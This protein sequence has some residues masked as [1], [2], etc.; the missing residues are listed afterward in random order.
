MQV[1]LHEFN[2]HLKN[3]GFY[4]LGIVILIGAGLVKGEGFIKDPSAIDK[5]F[6]QF[7]KSFLAV[8]GMNG[9]NISTLNGYYGLLFFYLVVIGFIYAGNLG[10]HIF[11]DEEVD[12]TSEFL[13]TKPISRTKLFINKY[14][15]GLIYLVLFNLAIIVLSEVII[16]KS[17]MLESI[18]P[19]IVIC[20]VSLF[21]TQWLFFSL[22]VMLVSSLRKLKKAYSVISTIV[23]VSYMLYIIKDFSVNLD[24]LK[25]ITPLSYLDLVNIAKLQEYSYATLGIAGIA[26][27]VFTAIGLFK[28]RSRDIYL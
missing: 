14:V 3:F 6:S 23:M 5:I 25:W 17:M 27:I 15:A 10:V 28:F 20:C 13:Y 22:G 2:K 19:M 12:K 1:L 18:L 24:W 26:A 11:A 8:F 21:I 9:F 4:V 7:P 16:T